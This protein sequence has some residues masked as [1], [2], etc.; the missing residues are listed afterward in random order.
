MFG[1]GSARRSLF[2]A[3]LDMYNGGEMT[4]SNPPTERGRRGRR[5]TGSAKSTDRDYMQTSIYVRRKQ[6]VQVNAVLAGR[7]I[8]KGREGNDFSDL[9]EE[10]L[11]NWLKKQPVDRA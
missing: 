3:F 10:L 6:Y 5:P 7:R 2:F 11:A 8:M 1:E 9:I 4:K